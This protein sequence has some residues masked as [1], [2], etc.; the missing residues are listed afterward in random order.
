MPL[1]NHLT[2]VYNIFFVQCIFW[3]IQRCTR[4]VDHPVY[5][6]RPSFKFAR[7]LTNQPPEITEPTDEVV[8][9]FRSTEGI[10]ESSKRRAEEVVFDLLVLIIAAAR[11]GGRVATGSDG[12]GLNC[13]PFLTNFFNL[14][15]LGQLIT[16]QNDFPRCLRRRRRRHRRRHRHV[17]VRHSRHTLCQFWQFS[18]GTRRD[19]SR[20]PGKKLGDCVQ[21]GPNY[22]HEHG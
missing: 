14:S 20:E 22:K 4:W 1:V 3:K 11:R 16:E 5:I 7:V 17:T 13:V 8:S 15:R 18:R 19:L 9:R 10:T 12:R 6:H 21:F 2:F